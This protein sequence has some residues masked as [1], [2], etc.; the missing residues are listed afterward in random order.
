M[1][2]AKRKKDSV[3]IPTVRMDKAFLLVTKIEIKL[4]DL[5]HE[6][7]SLI[8]SPLYLCGFYVE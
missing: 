8:N 2:V 3:S 1:E 5:D 4:H 7:D 6:S